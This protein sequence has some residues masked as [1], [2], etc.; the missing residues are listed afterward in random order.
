[1]QAWQA[2]KEDRAREPIFWQATVVEYLRR[3]AVLLSGIALITGLLYIS[4]LSFEFVWDDHLQV[5]SNPLLLSWK[6]I[7]RAFH[8]SLWFQMTP[9][10]KGSYYRPLFIVWSALNH[11]LFGFRPWGWHLTN[12]LLHIVASCVVFVLLRRLKIEY[13]TAALA[14]LAFA[15]HPVHIEPVA[16]IS[17]GADTLAAIL[18]LLTFLCFLRWRDGEKRRTGWML[19]SWALFACALLTK[20]MALTFP[21]ILLL[22]LWFVPQKDSGPGIVRRVGEGMLASLP[23]VVLN[24]LYLAQRARVLHSQSQTQT[25]YGPLATLLTLPVV[26]INY[27]RILIFPSGLTGFYYVPYVRG[28]SFTRFVLP[29]IGLALF[30]ALVWWW[31][32]R[33]RDPL[34]AF[35]GLWIPI[36]LI[37]VLYLPAFKNGDFVRD[38]YLYLPSVG[39]AFLLAKAIRRIPLRLPHQARPWL[40]PAAAAVT[41]VTFAFGV[42]TQQVYWANDLLV[43]HRGYT[44]YPQNTTA[45]KNLAYAFNLRGD[46]ASAM[47]LIQQAISADPD[48]YFSHWV[49]ALVDSEFHQDEQAKQELAKAVSLSPQYFL[50]TAHGLTNLGVAFAGAHEYEQA[51]SCFRRALAIEPDASSSLIYMGLV[52]LR[53]NRIADAEVFIKKASAVDPE[54]YNVNWALGMLAQMRGD[55]TLAER[56]YYEELRFH[57]DNRSAQ[58]SLRALSTGN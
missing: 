39:F 40:Q 43:F 20:E 5:E 36:C 13:W 30:T 52:L 18:Y 2:V 3:P 27:L 26:L 7:P 11:S 33:E 16:W 19:A 25:N 37:P 46:P 48:D 22:Y 32:R 14:T 6:A 31:S 47:S 54:G 49:L 34:I 10:G 45:V 23:Y 28:V 38:R 4:T 1:M 29:T 35:F 21:V 57:P 15:V 51:E 42:L 12:V 24:L 55:R 41:M 9:D 53:T 56:G 8:S 58:I 50:E 44:L 17:A